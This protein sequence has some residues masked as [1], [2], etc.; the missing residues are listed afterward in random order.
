MNVKCVYEFVHWG[1]NPT[2]LY[3]CKVTTALIT[4]MNTTITS[5][6][7]H[8]TFGKGDND[9]KAGCLLLHQLNCHFTISN[10]I[11]FKKFGSPTQSWNIFRKACTNFS[12]NWSLCRSTLVDWSQFIATTWKAWSDWSCFTSATTCWSHCRA[13]YS[14]TWIIWEISVSGITNWKLSVHIY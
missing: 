14:P 7:G 9:V 5:V 3:T 2:R 12:R 13:I 6:T 10:L 11:F 4:E 8:H 1:S